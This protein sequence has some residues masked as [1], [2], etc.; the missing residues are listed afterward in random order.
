MAE[1]FSLDDTDSLFFHEQRN[2]TRQYRR[3]RKEADELP[4]A[5]RWAEKS[6][7]LLV[8]QNYEPLK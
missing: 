6:R 8:A 1:V 5:L 3:F 7:D 2:K 4:Q